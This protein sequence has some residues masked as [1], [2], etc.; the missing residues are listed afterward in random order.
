[1]Y[2]TELGKK[3]RQ[4]NKTAKQAKKELIKQILASAGFEPTEIGRAHV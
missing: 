4:E 1:M 2:C 3:A